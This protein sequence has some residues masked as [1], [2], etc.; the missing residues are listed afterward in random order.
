M[1]R[2][3][4]HTFVSPARIT[5]DLSSGQSVAARTT[6]VLPPLSTRILFGGR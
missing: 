5:Q 4:A 6:I 3:T 1:G 2:D